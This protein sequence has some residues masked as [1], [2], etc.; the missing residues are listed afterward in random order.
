MFLVILLISVCKYTMESA[1]STAVYQRKLRQP[2]YLHRREWS[3]DSSKLITR[4]HDE[5]RVSELTH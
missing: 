3:D 2:S 5:N 4:G 1:T